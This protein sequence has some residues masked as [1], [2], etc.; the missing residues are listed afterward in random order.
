MFVHV[1]QACEFKSKDGEK[2]RMPFGFIGNIP[3]WVEHDA[4]FCS[5]V[6]GG[7]ICVHDSSK[8]VDAAQKDEKKKGK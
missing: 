3:A 1:K 6:R 8:A 4:L 5:M 2:F 7:L